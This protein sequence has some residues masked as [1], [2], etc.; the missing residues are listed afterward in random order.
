M[1]YKKRSEGYRQMAEGIEMKT[2]VHGEKTSMCEFRLAKGAEIPRHDHPHEQ[3][4]F[5]V[6]GVLRFDV[7]GEVFD[8]RAGDS[9]NLAGGKPHSATALEDTVVVEIFSPVREEYLP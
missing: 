8:A 5:M 9:W 7:E 3:T 6:S 4:G 2:L 1:F